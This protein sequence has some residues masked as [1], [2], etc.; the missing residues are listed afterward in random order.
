MNDAALIAL[1][2]AAV[3]R[4]MRTGTSVI[5]KRWLAHEII[6]AQGTITGKGADFARACEYHATQEIVGD[7]IRFHKKK[8]LEE[9]KQLRLPGYEHV[10]T[11][12]SVDRKGDDDEP[13][14]PC[15]VAITA[16]TF[17]EIRAKADQ[18]EAHGKACIAHAKELRRYA[19]TMTDIA[20]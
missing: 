6:T 2:H 20:V 19:A 14:E 12:Y 8:E 16:M 3:D 1:V 11:H 7:V 13:R 9:D 4:A 15:L 5:R 17:A 10:R 18:L